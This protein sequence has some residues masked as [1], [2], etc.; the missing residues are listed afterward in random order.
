MGQ[1][2]GPGVQEHHPHPEGKNWW[3]PAVCKVQQSSAFNH[4]LLTHCQE[5]CF[6]VAAPLESGMTKKVKIQNVFR[7]ETIG[8][9]PPHVNTCR[10]H[11]D[12]FF[13][14]FL[15]SCRVC[16]ID[17]E[18]YITFQHCDSRATFTVLTNHNCFLMI[19]ITSL[20][21]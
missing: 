6:S 4:K 16:A 13:F 10:I 7:S 12:F 19:L 9:P 15:R 1:P 21:T 14:V 11:L 2:G 3:L 8:H 18:L 20:D 17:S 5:C